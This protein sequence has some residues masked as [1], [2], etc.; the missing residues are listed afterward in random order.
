MNGPHLTT[1]NTQG[2]TG[3]TPWVACLLPGQVGHG[4]PCVH[5]VFHRKTHTSADYT[6]RWVASGANRRCSCLTGKNIL[7]GLTVTV[8][9]SMLGSGLGLGRP[10]PRL[11]GSPWDG[12]AHPSAVRLPSYWGFFFSTFLKTALLRSNLHTINVTC[13]ECSS[14]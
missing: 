6:A 4:W 9:S 14:Q 2:P 13:L 10:R 7:L 8:V 1:K 11:Q 5:T 12:A 3:Q